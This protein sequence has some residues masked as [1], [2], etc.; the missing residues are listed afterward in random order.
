M[1]LVTLGM[2]VWFFIAPTTA[3]AQHE[4]THSPYAGLETAEGTT[5][6]LEEIEQLRTGAGMRMALPAELS[7]YPGPKHALELAEALELT[8]AQEE[9]IRA[10]YEAMQ[11]DAAATG[12]RII[13]V[14]RHLTDAF[15]SATAD[16]TQ[17]ARMTDH[18]GSLQGELR[19]IHLLAHV[20][21]KAVLTE[22]QVREYDR[23]RGY[24]AAAPRDDRPQP[25]GPALRTRLGR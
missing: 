9:R 13:E 19:S 2:A 4:H 20:A 24:A 17:V 1:R 16:S 14:E 23:L 8:P 15:G 10:T 6:T 12:E 22:D 11:S 7:H 21:T 25:G 5:L 18:W 3:W